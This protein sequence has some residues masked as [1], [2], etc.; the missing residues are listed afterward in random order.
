[1]KAKAATTGSSPSRR[2]RLARVKQGASALAFTRTSSVY[3]SAIS[4]AP[5]DSACSPRG[6]ESRGTALLDEGRALTSLVFG[7]MLVIRTVWALSVTDIFI[8]Q[9]T[10]V[11]W[12][13]SCSALVFQGVAL[14]SEEVSGLLTLVLVPCIC[15]RKTLVIFPK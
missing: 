6:P 12:C 11:S 10:S 7:L 2:L 15:F 14:L 9:E 13:S 3:I 4:S 5:L 1:M 8:V